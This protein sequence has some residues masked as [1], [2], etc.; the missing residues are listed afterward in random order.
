MGNWAAS[1]KPLWKMP[2]AP[3][4]L[5]RPSSAGHSMR[6]ADGAIDILSHCVEI[7]RTTE[8]AVNTALLTGSCVFLAFAA[9]QKDWMLHRYHNTTKVTK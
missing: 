8:D 2:H 5:S 4:V 6:R 1:M 9:E 3:S 7:A